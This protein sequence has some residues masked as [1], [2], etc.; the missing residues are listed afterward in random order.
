MVGAG[1]VQVS[2]LRVGFGNGLVTDCLLIS[3]ISMLRKGQVGPWVL[4]LRQ[5]RIM[6]TMGLVDHA[7]SIMVDYC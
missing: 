3:E 4:A 6:R 1:S 5:R 2:V 7:R